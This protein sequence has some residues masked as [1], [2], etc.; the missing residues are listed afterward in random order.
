MSFPSADELVPACADESPAA[1]IT[2]RTVLEPLAGDGAPVKP[3]TYAGGVFQH[4]RRWWGEGADRRPVD[5]LVIDNEP[6]QANRLEAA[7]S[8]QREELGLPEIVLDLSEIGLL[9]PHL[10]RRISSFQFPHRNADAYLR[11]AL[12]DGA[13][14]VRSDIGRAVFDATTDRPEALL[15]WCPQALLYGFWQSHLGKKRSQAKAA[16][17]WMSEIIGVE[18]AIDDV[19]RLGL[20]GDPL[21]LSVTD[22]VSYNEMA[23]DEWQFSAKGKRL[24]DIGHGQVPVSGDDAALAGVS[25]RAVIQQSTVS[26]ASLRRIRAGTG[27]A[28]ARALLASLGLLAHVA[29]FSRPFSLRSGADLRPSRSEWTWLGEAGDR[30][31]EAPDIR[32]A[33]ALFAECT[34]RAEAAGLPVGSSWAADALILTPA[35]NL[36]E[37]IRKSWPVD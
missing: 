3:A 14:F 27:S 28:E 12:V 8:Q 7:L 18:P 32:S 6:S 10:P 4:G 17:S 25:F 13:P 16:R 33:D 30:P 34:R 26:F 35:P 37:A 36:A 1:G 5:I 9:P 19:R 31:F 11:D 20:K 15:Q 21:N 29:A 22:P 24:A 2:I 23:H